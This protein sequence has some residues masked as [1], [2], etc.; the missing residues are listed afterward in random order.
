MKTN[1]LQHTKATLFLVV[2]ATLISVAG[3]SAQTS[4]FAGTFTL[5]HEVVWGAA[6]LPPGSYT[7]RMTSIHAPGMVRSTDGKTQAYLLTAAAGDPEKG[8]ASLTIITRGSQR[9]VVSLNLPS[10]GVS[11]VYSPLTKSER[12]ILAKAKQIEA[13]PLI[14][15]K[16]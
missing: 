5:P 3:A 4:G 7:I 9:K 16:K 10:V 1:I 14:A 8:N 2:F 15:A 11:L 12:E 6:V 13:V